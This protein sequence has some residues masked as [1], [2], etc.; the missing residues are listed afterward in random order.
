MRL[1]LLKQ[2]GHKTDIKLSPDIILTMGY[3]S[4]DTFFVEMNFWR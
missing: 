2:E 3:P 4:L 1:K